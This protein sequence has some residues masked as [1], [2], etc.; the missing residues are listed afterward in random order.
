[1]I[2]KIRSNFEWKEREI[3]PRTSVLICTYN[4]GPLIDKTLFALIKLQ[5]IKPDQIVVVNGGG[6]DDCIKFLKKWK[7]SFPKL[8]IISTINKNLASSR[9][10]GLLHCS[11]DIILQTDD[12]AIP[13]SDWV[14]KNIVLH[15]L[16]PNVGVL[17]GPVIDYDGDNYLSAIADSTTFPKFKRSRYVRNVPGVNSSYKKQLIENLGEYDEN[18]FRGEDVDFNWRAIL[19]GWKILFHTDVKVYHRHRTTWYGL[20]EQHYMYG[21]AHYLVR[22]KWNNMYSHYPMK[23]DSIRKI[24]KWIASWTFIPFIDAIKKARH[25]ERYNN[26]FEVLTIFMINISN[27]VGSYKQKKINRLDKTC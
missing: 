20:F 17:G 5:S 8:K 27:R 23:I 9:N 13:F 16:Y 25:V 3:L 22:N 19:N 14:E 15:R 1:V 26:G 6:R 24:I 4:R 2:N 7:L 18:L 10:I 21:K 12:D 11:G